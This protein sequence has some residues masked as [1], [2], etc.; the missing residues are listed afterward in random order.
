MEMQDAKIALF[1]L[2][3]LTVT[4]TNL[5]QWLKVILLVVSITYTIIKTI[6]LK[7]KK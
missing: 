1:N 6:Q 7:K 2:S 4:F 5:E 3:A